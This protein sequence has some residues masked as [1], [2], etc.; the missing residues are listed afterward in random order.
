[1]RIDNFSPD[2]Q[3]RLQQDGSWLS[4]LPKDPRKHLL[5]SGESFTVYR[6][7]IDLLNLPIDQPD[8]QRAHQAVVSD[9]TV[10]AL[11]ANLPD[12]DT[13]LVT[14]HAKEDYLPN[15]LWLLLD[16]GIGPRDDARVETAYFKLLA[17]QDPETNQFLAY[18]KGFKDHKEAWTSVLCDHNLITSVLLHAGYQDD[19]RVKRGVKRITDLLVETSQGMGWKCEPGIGTKFRGPGR[20]D[21]ACPMAIIDALRGFWI[22]PEGNWPRELMDAGITLLQCWSNRATEKPYLFGHGQNFR[23]LRPPFFWYNIATVLDAT[24]HYSPLVR[25]PAF[26]ELLAVARQWFTPDGL[27][28]PQSVYLSFKKYSFGQKKVPS[29]WT[30][31]FLSRIC[32]RAAETDPDGIQVVLSIDGPSL[33][34]SKGKPVRAETGHA[35]G[36]R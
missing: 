20:K 16:W 18:C 9:P 36:K 29:P 24:S 31:L 12:W 1:M 13:Y 27:I 15:L 25:H 3:E 33:K 8:V 35:K 30:T 28:I 23:K 7:L 17:H 5:E 10:M 11:I 19:P 22:L 26:R 4:L 21:D 6:T 32:K 34:G 2:V 14:N